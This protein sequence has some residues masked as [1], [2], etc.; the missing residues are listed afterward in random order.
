MLHAS[1]AARAS[2]P[3]PPGGRRGGRF[4]RTGASPRR[5]CGTAVGGTGLPHWVAAAEARRRWVKLRRSTQDHVQIT[6]ICVTLAGSYDTREDAPNGGS[7]SVLPRASSSLSVS[8]R[9]RACGS[10]SARFG[11]TGPLEASA[12]P[13]PEVLVDAASGRG[14]NCSMADLAHD[15]RHERAF[16]GPAGR[17]IFM[18]VEWAGLPARW[19]SAAAPGV[20]SP[21]RWVGVGTP[22]RGCHCPVAKPPP[23]LA[24][25]L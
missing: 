16:S 4:R 6:P 22:V 12:G 2:Q 11:V 20:V 24:S 8:L 17:C 21:L 25:A 1:D 18:Q 19:E 9:R 3:C 13:L 5:F 7:V 15:P 23:R 10:T 14:D